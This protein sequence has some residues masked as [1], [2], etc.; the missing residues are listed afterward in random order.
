[1]SYEGA[2]YAT[3]GAEV[4][5]LA[6][7]LFLLH[8]VPQLAPFGLGRLVVAPI[9][10]AVGVG[11]GRAADLAVPWVLAAVLAVVVFSAVAFFG[12]LTSAA[13]LRGPARLMSRG[14]A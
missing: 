10:V 3:L 7:L 12:G 2:A 11:V 6:A 14:S 4:V 9:A 13:G 1:Y 5:V 8:G